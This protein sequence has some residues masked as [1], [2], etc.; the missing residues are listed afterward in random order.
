MNIIKKYIG[1]LGAPLMLLSI[2][3]CNDSIDQ[4]GI[5]DKDL[6]SV[7][8]RIQ[9]KNSFLIGSTRDADDDDYLNNG[10]GLLSNLYVVAIQKTYFD[11]QSK[12]TYKMDQHRIIVT[13]LNVYDDSGKLENPDEYYL[14]L[15]PGDYKFYVFAN[16]DLYADSKYIASGLF[17]EE[18]IDAFFVTYNSTTPIRLGHLPMKCRPENMK[19]KLPEESDYVAVKKSTEKD[20]LGNLKTYLDY[21][22]PVTYDKTPVIYADLSFLCAKVRYT[23]LFDDTQPESEPILDDEGNP[24]G[25]YW[26]EGISSGFGDKSI[27]FNVDETGDYRPM[28]SNLRE[29]TYLY[30]EVY[31]EDKD[32]PTSNFSNLISGT[33]NLELNRYNWPKDGANYPVKPSQKLIPWT[34]SVEDWKQSRRRAWQGVV[35]LPENDDNEVDH[36]M[37]TFPYVLD[38]YAKGEGEDKIEYQDG[39]PTEGRSKTIWLFGN[40]N[41]QHFASNGYNSNYENYDPDNKDWQQNLQHVSADH[42]IKRGYFY[43]VVA[44]CKNPDEWDL[45]VIV[46]GRVEDWHDIEQSVTED[47]GYKK[48]PQTNIMTHANDWQYDYFSSRW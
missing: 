10:E 8:L 46:Y 39:D 14:T 27:R 33:W 5:L 6:V 15:Y 28:V 21:T 11:Q 13:P 24:T 2:W 22:I 37:L 35:Y 42:G 12:K 4:G 48:E 30:P 23:I 38:T 36:T 40:N 7:K 3:G 16:T 34:G 17:T 9:N 44:R 19:Y 41:E 47:D 20:E 29:A 32:K 1:L 31:P 45:K 43:D 26:P 25:E 18:E